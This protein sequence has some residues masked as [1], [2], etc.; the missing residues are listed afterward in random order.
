MITELALGLSLPAAAQHRGEME[1]MEGMKW[2][3]TAF[4][5]AEVLEYA[6]LGEERPIR[7]DLHAWVGGSRGRVWAKADGE[8]STL[9]DVGDTE[10]QLLYGWM[11][12]PW[13][14]LQ[15][16]V[17]LDAQYGFDE[18]AARPLLAVGLQGLA[19]GWFELE[20]TLFVS[21]RGELSANLTAS[22]ELL[23]TQRLVAQPRLEAEVGVQEVADWGVGSGLNE[24]DLGL[25][26]R[27]ELWREFAP[28][29]GVSW[30]GRFTEAA[31]EP[32]SEVSVVAGLRLWR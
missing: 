32:P 6:P 29:A 12:S 28:Y 20:P 24:L 9:S 15:L 27:Y 31:G 21:P 19:P 2:S 14:D 26:L 30:I 8:Q 23:L 5:L 17:R 22:Y 1:G 4:A 11:F 13:W 16:G 18:A 25:R 10:L 3:P 7:Y